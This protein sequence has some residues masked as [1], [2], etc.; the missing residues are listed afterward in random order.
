M[1]TMA[2]R[3]AV[4]TTAISVVESMFI[5]VGWLVGWVVVVISTL[6][7]GLRSEGELRLRKDYPLE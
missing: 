5:L 2:A 4:N 6:G 1:T 3:G 7:G